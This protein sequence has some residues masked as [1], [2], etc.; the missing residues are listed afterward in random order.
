MTRAATALLGAHVPGNTWLHRLPAGAKLAGLFLAGLVV[1]LVRGPW[2]ALVGLVV[3]LGVLASSGAGLRTTFSGLRFLLLTVS[4]LGAFHVWQ[5]GWP[6]AVEVVADLLGLVL[7]ATAVTVATPVDEILDAVVRALR[8]FSRLGVDAEQV[9][10][11]FSLLLRSI[12]TT[13]AIAEET[14]DAAI[15]RG[16]ERDPRARLTPLVIRVVA[17]ARETG[18]ALHAR[19]LGDD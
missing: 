15:A 7:L 5:N 1:V 8:P 9:A 3:A 11:A 13:L 16:L 6:R 12:P 4:V 17:H 19:G 18:D 14:R 2:P 10:L